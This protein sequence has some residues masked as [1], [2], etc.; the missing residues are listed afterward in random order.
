MEIS[1]FQNNCYQNLSYHPWNL[2]HSHT[3]CMLLTKPHLVYFKNKS[4]IKRHTNPTPY[5]C[6]DSFH[7]VLSHIWQN[8]KLTT[9]STLHQS[10]TNLSFSSSPFPSL[11][12]P[13]HGLHYNTIS[14]VN[15]PSCFLHL[16]NS[17]F[18]VQALTPIQFLLPQ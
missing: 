2:F 12:S 11:F 10:H 7:E 9:H 13:F 18:I 1:Y 14:A 16:L 4:S 5:S 3:L 6:L 8:P 17:L 15:N